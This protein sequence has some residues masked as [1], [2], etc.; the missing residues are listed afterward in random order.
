MNKAATAQLGTGYL[1]FFLQL[2][3]NG[4]GPRQRQHSLVWAYHAGQPRL[5]WTMPHLI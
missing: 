5:A 4:A 3:S 1:Q 2:Q